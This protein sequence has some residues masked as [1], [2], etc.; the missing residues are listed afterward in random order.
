MPYFV[1]ILKIEINIFIYS[2]CKML[3]I[4]VSN[5]VVTFLCFCQ[6]SMDKKV[7]IF[8][9]PPTYYS[10]SIKIFTSDFWMVDDLTRGTENV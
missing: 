2:I 8:L 9:F 5:G 7:V 10:R 4:S 6:I 1:I 3:T